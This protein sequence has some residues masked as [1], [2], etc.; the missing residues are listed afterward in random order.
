MA[1]LYER[2]LSVTI[3]SG[4]RLRFVSFPRGFQCRLAIAAR[5]GQGLEHLAVVADGPPQ[6]MS[7]AADP[8]EN[9]TEMPAPAARPHS[10]CA[11]PVDIKNGTIGR[12]NG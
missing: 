10:R 8:H 4:R 1:A 9:L 7:L 5:G 2:P 12:D 11:S 3:G 6:A